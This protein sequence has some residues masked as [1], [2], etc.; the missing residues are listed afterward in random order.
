MI[1]IYKITNK[2][3]GNIYIGLSVDI[4]RRWQS[5]KQRYH[6]KSNKE[7]NKVLYKA[8]HKYGI[9]NFTFEIIEE[10]A[11][12]QL[13]EREKYWIAYYDSYHNGYN[14]TPGGDDIL[15]MP[16]EKHPNHKLTEDDVIYIRE[17]WASKT[18]STREMYYEF[19]DQ[20]GKSGFKKIH[21]WQTWKNI[22]PELNTEENRAWHAQNGKSYSNAYADN[23]KAV[24]TNTQYQDIEKR[25]LSGEFPKAIYEDYKDKY[26]SYKSFYNSR[27]SKLKK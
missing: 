25:Y 6:K 23:P 26:S 12:E 21:T 15:P 10:C 24:L 18:L 19:Q 4:Y 13:R 17:L 16:G 9:E 3:N 20:I 22:L 11:L 14:A 7:Y 8:F 1:G 5:H 27:I 2:I